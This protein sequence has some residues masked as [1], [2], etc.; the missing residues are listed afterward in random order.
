MHAGRLGTFAF[1]FPI[2]SGH[3]DMVKGL[4][5]QRSERSKNPLSYGLRVSSR[6]HHDVWSGRVFAC[7]RNGPA[8]NFPYGSMFSRRVDMAD[9]LPSAFGLALAF[10]RSARGW[11]QP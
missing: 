6:N 7:P 10:L 4:A 1:R 11:I 3:E 8:G 5:E 2:R 9:G